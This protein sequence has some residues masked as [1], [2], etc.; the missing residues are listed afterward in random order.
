MKT[1]WL[2]GKGP[3]KRL[4]FVREVEV[5]T[6][7][8]ECIHRKVCDKVMENRCVNFE[9][10]TSAAKGCHACLHH[11]TRF[12]IKDSV[13]CFSCPDFEPAPTNT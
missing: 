4:M 6:D 3:E 10:G 7:C 9:F 2:Y 8:G 11:Y 5:E 13:P 12:D 1:H